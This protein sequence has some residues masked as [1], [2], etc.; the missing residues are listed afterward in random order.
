ME[1]EPIVF[2]GL[3]P[4]APIL[5]PGVGGVRLAEAA[6]TAR[7]MTAVAGRAV[8][9]RPE[10]LVLISPHSPRRPGAFGLWRTRRL[11]GSL[12]RFGSPE[13]AVD[14]PL[15]R[16]FADRLEEDAKRAGLRTWEIPRGPLDHGA[17]V[18]LCYLRAAG[19]SGP[20]VI[21][22]NSAAR[23]PPRHGPCRGAPR[24]SRAAT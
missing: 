7:A 21:L 15:D 17:V 11:G 8:A 23:S 4:H 16:D 10:T 22:R 14:L 2:A 20:T 6:S 5:V 9:A 12:D 3:M 24:S 13:D 19:W 18:P 1:P